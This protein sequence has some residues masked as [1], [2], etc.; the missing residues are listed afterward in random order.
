MIVKVLYDTSLGIYGPLGTR[1]VKLPK[2][3][4]NGQVSIWD[5]L[6]GWLKRNV[7]DIAKPLEWWRE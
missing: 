2:Y 7:L 4:Q 5:Y 6:T 1:M 3:V